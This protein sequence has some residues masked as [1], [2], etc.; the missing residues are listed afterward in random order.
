MFCPKSFYYRILE[1][2]IY[3]INTKKYISRYI[4]EIEKGEELILE[5]REF[6]EGKIF[7]SLLFN[8]KRVMLYDYVDNVKYIK[9]KK[10]L[11]LE[12]LKK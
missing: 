2:E 9:S 1:K 10:L 5:S 11:R 3:S 6:Y 8:G 4:I 12:K 7:M